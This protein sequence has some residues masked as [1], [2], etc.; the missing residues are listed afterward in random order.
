MANHI[1]PGKNPSA[2]ILGLPIELIQSITHQFILP[3]DILNFSLTC[4]SIRS[5][6]NG[7]PYLLYEKDA[8]VRQL[9]M[10]PADQGRD[11]GATQGG[12]VRQAIAGRGLLMRGLARSS[13]WLHA[14][15]KHPD[16]GHIETII[17]VYQKICGPEFWRDGESLHPLL[18]VIHAH[19]PAL[20]R[21]LIGKGG[22]LE[23]QSEMADKTAYLVA[24]TW[25][26]E[27]IALCIVE[28]VDD[29]AELHIAEAIRHNFPKVVRFLLS[30]PIR[31]GGHRLSL[32]TGDLETAARVPNS[33]E[34]MSLLLE[35]GAS[36][37]AH[38]ASNSITKACSVGQ[39]ENAQYLLQFQAKQGGIP[40]PETWERI[41]RASS[42]SLK[43]VRFLLEN[44][45]SSGNEV[46]TPA[47]IVDSLYSLLMNG[48]ALER[49]QILEYLGRMPFEPS[50]G[51][52]DNILF[53]DDTERLDSM[54]KHGLLRYSDSLPAGS[55]VPTLLERALGR[56]SWRC[57]F[58][59]AHY[60]AS[61][62]DLSP[63]CKQKLIDNVQMSRDEAGVPIPGNYLSSLLV[64]SLQHPSDGI[65]TLTQFGYSRLDATQAALYRLLLGDDVIRECLRMSLE[66]DHA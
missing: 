16:F 57:A 27:D 3:S 36:I 30:Q 39:F 11:S 4:S 63:A 7:L 56:G 24:C 35:A 43:F 25:K 34:I 50:E 1:Q 47:S 20:F 13:G 2:P 23:L 15:M 28:S 60:G 37:V 61:T 14:I 66:G 10:L 32:L 44:Y 52:V 38:D 12:L 64:R 48:Y 22:S 17:K 41:A 33:G 49:R 46:Y 62:K 26:E 45:L 29:H 58:A 21:Q 54:F 19:R 59:L 18:V 51:L 42:H 8:Q 5:I 65:K 55:Q 6:I 40:G 9:S 31:G 53:C